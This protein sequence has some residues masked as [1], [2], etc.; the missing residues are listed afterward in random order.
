MSKE[1]ASVHLQLTKSEA[2]LLLLAFESG[3][4]Q[5]NTFNVMAKDIMGVKTDDARQKELMDK[6]FSLQKE[7][8]K[9][10]YKEKANVPTI[11]TGE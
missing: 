11:I 4:L 9:Q 6:I 8:V 3:A 2:T 10:I 7:L 5:L 1:P